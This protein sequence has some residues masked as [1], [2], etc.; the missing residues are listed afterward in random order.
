MEPL[1]GRAS[2]A[3][4][5]AHRQQIVEAASE[6]LREHG[7]AEVSIP[8]I[9]AQAQ[10][11]HGG[12]YRHFASKDELVALATDCAFTSTDAYLA[13]TADA[14]PDPR[15]ANI[16]DYLS[17][18]RRDAPAHGCAMTGLASDVSREAPDS[19]V[20]ETFAHGV[21]VRIAR[22]ATFRSGD[23]DDPSARAAAIADLAAMVGGAILARATAGTP[24][25]DEILDS[26]T[27][28]LLA[29]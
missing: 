15:G 12:F 1:V 5:A 8:Q 17:H 4:A 3:D 21:E 28:S 10:L 19:S 25:S 27:A 23:P 26:V 20:R 11:T 6:L 24:L 29:K 7:I 14:A 16:T 13:E 9:M 2:R 22:G 18:A